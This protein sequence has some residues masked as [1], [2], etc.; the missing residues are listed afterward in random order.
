MSI[1]DKRS[2]LQEIKDHLGKQT[3][4]ESIFWILVGIIVLVFGW[5][6]HIFKL[7]LVVFFVVISGAIF[8]DVHKSTV[9]TTATLFFIIWTFVLNSRSVETQNRNLE[10]QIQGLE[11]QRKV[12]Q[13]QQEALEDQ[14]RAHQ[15][16]YRPYISVDMREAEGFN[17]GGG[18]FYGNAI[19]LKNSGKVPAFDINTEYY[20]TDDVLRKNVFKQEYFIRTIGGYPAISFLFP[21]S[22]DSE[23]GRRSL[24]SDAE[25]YYFEALARYK[26]LDKKTQYWTHI[27]R[28]F[29]IEKAKINKDNGSIPIYDLQL[30]YVDGNWDRNED[31]DVIP[32]LSEESDVEKLLEDIK[33]QRDREREKVQNTKE[34]TPESAVNLDTPQ[35]STPH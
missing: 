32:S 3:Y 9:M 23:P 2:F 16:E 12:L 24:N 27:K 28:V 35:S 6:L 20:M 18:T 10:T 17:N 30:V 4:S 11:H 21:N 25:Y 19:I 13:R 34:L 29:Y 8:L 33:R 5:K 26:G 31:F 22:E 14:K 15:I 1:K 7:S